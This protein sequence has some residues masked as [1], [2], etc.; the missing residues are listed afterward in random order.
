MWNIDV[1]IKVMKFFLPAWLR[2]QPFLSE[3]KIE[4]HRMHLTWLIQRH[5]VTLKMNLND[6]VCTVE[7][8]T[9]NAVTWYS[10]KNWL[11]FYTANKNFLKFLEALKLNA[12]I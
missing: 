4:D 6:I 5:V 9:G 2:K 1:K 7:Q 12:Q 8:P 10:T 3:Y 11:G